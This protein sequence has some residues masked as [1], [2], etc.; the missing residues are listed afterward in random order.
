MGKD[1]LDDL[2]MVIVRKCKT[3]LKFSILL[4]LSI[5]SALGYDIQIELNEPNP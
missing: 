4:I 5:A 3:F 2:L 1:H